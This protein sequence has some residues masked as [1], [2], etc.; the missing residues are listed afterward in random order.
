[1]MVCDALFGA[2]ASL[3]SPIL[4]QRYAIHLGKSET[5]ILQGKM[6]ISG[7]WLYRCFLALAKFLGKNPL[8]LSKDIPVTVHYRTN[9]MSNE[10]LFD[11]IF[12]YPGKPPYYL[13]SKMIILNNNQVIEMMSG[14]VGCRLAYDVQGDDMVLNHVGF[15]IKL[16]QRFYPLPITWLLGKPSVVE[17]PLDEQTFYLKMQVKHFTGTLVAYEG[18]FVISSQS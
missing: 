9:D 13:C 15:A 10:V 18:S 3:L 5:I 4:A 11:R 1:M 17:Q 12:H 16:G 2:K 7:S 14:R 6:T 8:A